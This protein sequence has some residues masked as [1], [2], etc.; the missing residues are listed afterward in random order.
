[1]RH[2][3]R[4]SISVHRQF[5]Y[6]LVVSLNRPLCRS[7]TR[8]RSLTSSRIFPKYFHWKYEKPEHKISA[9]IAN[10]IESTWVPQRDLL[11]DPRL[12]AFITH[13]GQ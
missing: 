4:F 12:S 1:M 3:Q 11:N 5:T 7:N 10:L 9:G 2:G 8:K 6:L 13:C